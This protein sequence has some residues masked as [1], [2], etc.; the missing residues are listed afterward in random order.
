MAV[1]SVDHF[2]IDIADLKTTDR[3]LLQ[4]VDKKG[5][6]YQQEFKDQ[7]KEFSEKL[8][9]LQKTQRDM[10]NSLT[11]I[12]LGGPFIAATLAAFDDLFGNVTDKLHLIVS[13]L[14]VELGVLLVLLVLLKIGQDVIKSRSDNKQKES[15]QRMLMAFKAELARLTVSSASDQP[16]PPPETA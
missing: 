5:E 14:W 4:V 3:T 13:A 2:D 7:L 12:Q 15:E 10:Q 1:R 16:N 11:L 9:P 8:Q 6:K